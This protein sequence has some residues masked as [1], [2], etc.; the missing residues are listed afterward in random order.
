M[1]NDIKKGAIESLVLQA[2]NDL[3]EAYGYQIMRHLKEKNYNFLDCEEGTLYPLLYR[4]ESNDWVTS[5]EKDG[6][7]GKTRRY[8]KLTSSGKLRLKDRKK[9]F[10][11]FYHELKNALHLAI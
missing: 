7:N 1:N 9:E 8:Y 4:L 11:S 5:Q 10:T 2:L 3:G 6:V